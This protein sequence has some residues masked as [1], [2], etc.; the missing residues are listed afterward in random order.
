[1]LTAGDWSPSCC[2]AGSEDHGCHYAAGAL[3]LQQA[4]A[5]VRSQW[6]RHRV[7]RAGKAAGRDTWWW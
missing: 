4:L 7:K 5:A 3:S 1:M 6:S 2:P